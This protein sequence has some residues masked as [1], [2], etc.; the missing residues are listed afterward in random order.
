[1]EVRKKLESWGMWGNELEV[2]LA[3]M[4]SENFLNEERFARA[5][6]RGKFRMNGFGK[7]RI[8]QRLKSYDI[9]DFCIQVALEEI[10]AHNYE[11]TLKH[12]IEKRISL[13]NITL[14][15]PIEKQALFRYFLNKGFEGPLINSIL[16]QIEF[17]G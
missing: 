13:K 11:D 5:Y 14:S 6:A 12:A 3:Q 15:N 8:I 7:R 16:N 17:P 2:L 10:D 1:M 9:S 4:I